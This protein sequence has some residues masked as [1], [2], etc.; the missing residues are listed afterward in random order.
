MPHNQQR[1]RRPP[2]RSCHPSEIEGRESKAL[3]HF[4]AAAIAA[5]PALSQE[6]YELLIDPRCGAEQDE[7]TR[8]LRSRAKALIDPSPH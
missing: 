4:K 1:N 8:L 7:A 2:I 3:V 6:E 5:L